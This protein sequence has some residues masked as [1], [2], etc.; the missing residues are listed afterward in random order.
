MSV[1]ISDAPA[2][3][4]SARWPTHLDWPRRLA[5]VGVLTVVLTLAIVIQG[6][7]SGDVA[8]RVGA[9]S[10]PV[11]S[12][13]PRASQPS[14]DALARRLDAQIAAPW[15]GL[16]QPS[17]RFRNILGGGTRFGEA[18]LGYALLQAGARADNRPQIHAGLK[19]IS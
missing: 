15:P 4:S 7:D 16:Q 3:S 9:G 6:L 13:G 14:L 12:T 1:F 8:V 5:I 2:V 19:A 17:G 11:A 10:K 18:T